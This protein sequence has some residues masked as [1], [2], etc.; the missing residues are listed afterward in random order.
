MVNEYVPLGITVDAAEPTAR[1]KQHMCM[2]K[3][4]D[5][6]EVHKLLYYSYTNHIWLKTRRGNRYKE[7]GKVYQPI[8]RN[9]G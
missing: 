6:P 5:F 7:K 4:Y 3:G 8:N 2:D 1:A 9:T